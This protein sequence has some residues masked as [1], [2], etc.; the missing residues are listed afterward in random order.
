MDRGDPEGRA[1]REDRADQ[2]RDRGRAEDRDRFV[3]RIGRVRGRM[4]CRIRGQAIVLMGGP[5]ISI[6][7][8]PMFIPWPINLGFQLTPFSVTIPVLAIIP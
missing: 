8:I 2:D 3:L 4:R 5:L 7:M 6:P 1:D